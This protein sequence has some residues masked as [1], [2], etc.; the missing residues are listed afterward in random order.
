MSIKLGINGFGRIGRMV[1]RAALKHP[2]VDVVA[3]NDLTDSET[4]AYL[5]KYDSVHGQLD[6]D[7]KA[8]GDSIQVGDKTIAIRSVKDPESIGWGNLGVDI[9]AECTGIFRDREGASKHLAAGA[10]KVII[11]APAGNPDITIVM[12]V[13]S[14]QYD[15]RQHH[16]ISNASCTTNC[17]AP[18]AKVLLENFGLQ[19]GLMTT[20]HAYTG[21]QRLL[22]FPHKDFRRARSAALSMIPTTTGAAKAVALVLPE[23]SGKLNGLA[24]RVPT[25]NVS[26]VDLVATVDKAGINVS[27]VNEALKQASEGSLAGILGYSDA[28]LVSIDYNGCSLSSTVD[29]PTTYVIENMVK[30]LSWYDNETG[31]S[32]RMVDL[33]AMIGKEL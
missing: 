1:L 4:M 6:L 13:N 3:I 12:G 22:D 33:A 30:V 26:L 21:D 20:I 29:A 10:R 31:Y 8:K 7:V 17:L 14:N 15:P 2:D 28:P 9:A 19:R 24:I 16:I 23:L 11:S 32:H 18:V 5:L 25:P 27:D